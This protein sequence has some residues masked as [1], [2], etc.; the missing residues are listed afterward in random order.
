[1]NIKSLFLLLIV[2]LLL[3]CDTAVTGEPEGSLLIEQDG[4]IPAITGEIGIIPDTPVL[5]DSCPTC[6]SSAQHP[7]PHGIMIIDENMAKEFAEAYNQDKPTG[8]NVAASREFESA[9]LQTSVDLSS[10][11]PYTS[12]NIAQRNQGYCGNCWAWAGT[13]VIEV[14]HSVQNGIKGQL[15]VQYLNSNY[16]SGTG[17][18]YACCGGFADDFEIFYEDEGDDRFIPW[19]NAGA[20]YADGTR[21][22]GQ[23]TARSASQITTTPNYPF[24]SLSTQQITTTGVTRQTAINNIKSMLNQNKAVWLGFYWYDNSADFFNAWDQGASY[25]YNPVAGVGS[26]G[27]FGGHAMTIIGYEDPNNDGTGYWVVLNSWGNRNNDPHLPGTIRFEMNI[28]YSALVPG[29]ESW[30]LPVSM[31][32]TY[33]VQFVSATDPAP[34]VTSVTPATGE[35][36]GDVSITNLAGSNFRSG[37]GVKLTRSGYNDITASDVVVVSASQI[38][39]SFN[40][41]GKQPGTWDVVVTNT[42]GQSGTKTGAFTITGQEPTPASYHESGDIS[43]N[44]FHNYGP[45][46]VSSGAEEASFILDGPSGADFDLYV[47]RGREASQSEWDWRPY[48][49]DADEEVIL[50]SPDSGDYYVMVHA[51]S[52]SGSY[53]LDITITGGF[54]EPAP[55]VSGITP[56][57]G[58]N[59]GTVSI[60]DLAGSNFVNGATVTLTR[61]GQSDIPA[62]GVVVESDTKITCAFD[63]TGKTSGNWNVVVTNPGGLSDTLEDGFFISSIQSDF[64][65]WPTTGVS[66]LKVYFIDKSA[67]FPP[68]T[69]WTWDFTDDGVVDASGQNVCWTFSAPGTYPVRLTVG[70][71]LQNETISM[72]VMRQ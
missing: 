44:Q 21:S 45:Y 59:E 10:H 2:L 46:P 6:I 43:Y 33:N 29:Y 68:P 54:Q 58:L 31:Y 64:T 55:A 67:G 1:M 40:L 70:N 52:G 57:S 25:E 61:T 27:D 42:D 39:C 60:T 16:N 15:S 72:A 9:N 56:S 69:T 41:I 19:S 35:N 24:T 37:A 49:Y 12:G 38:T 3:L 17:S 23:S 63:L 28:D 8:Y 34:V 71:G 4:V 5:K 18:G 7:Y 36:T 66:P 62:T 47:A 53:T 30:N 51:Y 22:C 13:G 11:V 50:S 48:E 20:S 32:Y 65:F 14:A 26:S